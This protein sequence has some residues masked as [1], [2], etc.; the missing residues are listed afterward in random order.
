[1]NS[2]AH[3]IEE[4][5]R[6]EAELLVEQLLTHVSATRQLLVVLELALGRRLGT[7]LR[8]GCRG[9]LIESLDFCY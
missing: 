2:F 1:M 4:L 3:N 8:H 6:L 9:P 7:T 5:S